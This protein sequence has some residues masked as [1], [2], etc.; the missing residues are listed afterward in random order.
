MWT[1]LDVG[2]AARWAAWGLEPAPALLDRGTRS[3]M[4]FSTQRS[5]HRTE[6]VLGSLHHITTFILDFC[7]TGW[8]KE[9]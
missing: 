1:V 3:P 9:Y 2:L 8:T 4:C 7:M 5:R 6:S